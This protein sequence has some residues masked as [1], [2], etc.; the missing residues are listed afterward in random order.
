MAPSMK[1]FS[2][3][4]KTAEPGAATPVTD[5]RVALARQILSAGVAGAGAGVAIRALGGFRNIGREPVSAPFVS[6]GPSTLPIPIGT[7][8]DED[9]PEEEA[10]LKFAAGPSTFDAAAQ[11]LSQY[12]PQS[13]FHREAVSIPGTVLTGG[14]GLLGGWKLTDWIL[15]KRRKSE[16]DDELNRAKAE[17]AAALAGGGAKVAS[18]EPTTGELLDQLLDVLEKDAN[19]GLTSPSLAKGLGVYELA[20]A[21]AA[22]GAAYGT[23]KWTKNRSDATL[24]AKAQKERAR[25]LW[26]NNLQPIYVV[27]Q[28]PE[29]AAAAA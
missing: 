15:D 9:S 12:M 8:E 14:A 17:Y 27:P 3:L 20:A 28:T 4:L 25:K 22:G 6:P 19:T 16:M 11:A 7:T 1:S 29:A 18:A 21:L 26:A 23:Y 10:N 24:L 5:P 2:G 13:S